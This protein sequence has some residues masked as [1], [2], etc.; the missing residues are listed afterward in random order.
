MTAGPA[1]T[2][3]WF[4]DDLRL[5]DNAALQWAA[6]RGQVIAV[7]IDEDAAA[8]GARPRGAAA[9]WWRDRSLSQLSGRLLDHG[10]RLLHLAG[11]PV[12][13]MTT[14]PGIL[15]VDAVVWN[16]RY[17]EPLRAVDRRV[18]DILQGGG[19]EVHSF[20][21]H[22]L[23]EPWQITTGEGRPY[24]VFTP[25]SRAATPVAEDAVAQLVEAAAQVPADLRGPEEDL[26]EVPF[27]PVRPVDPA[28]W[29]ASLAAHWTPGEEAG[30]AT[31]AAF[32]TGDRRTTATGSPGY[33]DGRDIPDSDATT[34]LSPHLRFGEVSPHRVWFAVARAVAAGDLPVADGTSLH[35]ELLWRDFAWQRLYHRPDLASRCVRGQFTQ[36]PWRWDDSLPGDVMR[37]GGRTALAEELSAW[38]SGTT[39]IPLVDAGMR[40]LWATGWMHNRVRMVVGS[41][42]T[43]NLLIDWRHGE[44]WFWDTLVDADPA[45][46]PFNWQWI[47]GCGDDASPY[48]R[49]FNPETQRRKFDPDLR[50]VNRWIPDLAAR[51]EGRTELYPPPLVD[52]GESRQRALAAYESLNAP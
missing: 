47:A 3:V 9:S 5:A 31:L 44:Q 6:Q 50:Y 10:V 30:Q 4:R 1:T 18:K 34:R 29:T 41:F 36:F 20:P 39:G 26:P 32:V 27:P 42:L 35:S 17:E 49:I 40:E 16:R 28:P 23:T 48:F 14:L 19:N 38:R 37:L 45:S 43:K 33:A 22:L 25:Y 51:T 46:N 15:D 21:G 8:T 11:D 2:L 7:V 12:E 24:R 52:L 13:I